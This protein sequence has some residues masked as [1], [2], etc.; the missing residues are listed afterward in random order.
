M[1]QALC[2][3]GN[4]NAVLVSVVEGDL[5][6]SLLRWARWPDGPGGTGHSAVAFGR[7]VKLSKAG[8]SR[9]AHWLCSTAFSSYR[10]SLFLACLGFHCPVVGSFVETFRFAVPVVPERAMATA[11]AA[12]PT[13]T[14][15]SVSS[16]LY[17]T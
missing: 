8:M 17:I 14:T 7:R 4:R 1:L 12:K 3:L 9:L 16:R 10:G 6:V 15:G 13:A 11:A 5:V 2:W